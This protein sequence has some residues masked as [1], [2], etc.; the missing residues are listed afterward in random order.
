LIPINIAHLAVFRRPR[1]G[2][3]RLTADLTRIR[4][5]IA[6]ARACSRSMKP[7]RVSR[8]ATKFA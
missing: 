2:N 4:K 6:V 7:R 1:F 5:S 3:K 8:S